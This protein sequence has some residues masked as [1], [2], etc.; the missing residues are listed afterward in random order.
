MCS[1]AHADDK[2]AALTRRQ[3]GINECGINAVGIGKYQQV[4]LGKPMVLDHHFP[5]P[6]GT[7]NSHGPQRAIRQQRAF[8]KNR[9]DMHQAAG[10]KEEFLAGQVGMPARPED[11]DKPVGRD[12]LG[13]SSGRGFHGRLLL[14]MNAAHQI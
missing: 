1:R 2:D 3:R 4:T 9:V 14:F 11:V 8:I 7:L 5:V 12:L 13:H 6:R 10:A